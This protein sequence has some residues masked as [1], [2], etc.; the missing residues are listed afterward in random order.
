MITVTWV[1]VFCLIF[2]FL[3]LLVLRRHSPLSRTE[4]ITAFAYKAALGCLYGYLFGTYY[5]GD[6]TWA[7]HVDSIREWQLLQKD[8]LQFFREYSPGTA[9]RNGDGFLEVAAFY[10]A[11]LE[12][13]L[14]TKTLG[15]FNVIS[16]GNYYINA[17]FFNFIVF[18]GHYWLYLLAVRY[19]RGNRKLL[20]LCIFFLPTAVFWLSGI[21]GDGM[22]FFFFSLL[23]LSFDR[24]LDTGKP[25]PAILSLI[26]FTGMMIFRTPVALLLLPALISWVLIRKSNKYPPLAF[27]S[28][29]GLFILLFFASSLLT[30]MN[31]PSAVANQQAKFLL[32]KGNTRYELPVLEPDIPGFITVLPYAFYN[33]FLRP[34]PW[35]AKGML[36]LA[37][38]AGILLFWAVVVYYLFRN[39]S[40]AAKGSSFMWV[41]LLFGISLYL[42]IGYMVP[43][44]GAIVRYKS[45][46]EMVILL[47]L[48]GGLSTNLRNPRRL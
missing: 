23:L 7:I 39:R 46:G 45:I 10:I 34:L 16:R 21:R 20:L 28:V 4:T 26:G 29:Y 15:I 14:L 42:L 30:R 47:A 38:A 48:L 24:W 31:G 41:L 27:I 6:D 36:Q 40:R 32:L 37:S 1:I 3:I 11:D 2:V 19:F 9:M 13:C 17:V 12:Y 18:W 25:G 8:P 33:T 44:P 5:G 43:F 35:E 22:L